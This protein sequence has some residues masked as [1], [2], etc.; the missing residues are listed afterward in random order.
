V[1][2]RAAVY[3]SCGADITDTLVGLAEDAAD[4]AQDR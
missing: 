4:A 3:L 1:C 2:K